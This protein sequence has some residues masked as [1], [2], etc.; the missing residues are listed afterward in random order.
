MET[1]SSHPGNVSIPISSLNLSEVLHFVMHN[2]LRSPQ[3]DQAPLPSIP[4]TIAPPPP[5]FSTTPS[6]HK[7]EPGLPD[8]SSSAVGSGSHPYHLRPQARSR[9]LG[10][11][12]SPGRYRKPKRGRPSKINLAIQS[13]VADVAQGR[14]YTI[15]RA[16][17]AIE[18]LTCGSP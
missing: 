18:P 17:R 8:P 6:S 11:G 5:T 3:N 4:C 7:L 9:M 12:S 1:V 2:S 13:A 15:E 16:L 14:Q 10:L